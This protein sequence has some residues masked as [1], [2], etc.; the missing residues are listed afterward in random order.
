MTLTI[1]LT[2][3]QI[4]VLE[5]QARRE[6]LPAEEYARR[7]LVADLIGTELP[8]MPPARNR[9]EEL[10]AQWEAEDAK[11]TPEELAAEAADWEQF[12]TNLNDYRAEQGQE[13]V[14]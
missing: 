8:Q 5:E 9:T 6:G 10:L 4:H 2:P 13:P 11:L 3:E 14:Y 1:E 12:Q 7:R